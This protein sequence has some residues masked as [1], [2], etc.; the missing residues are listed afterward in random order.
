MLY[1]PQHILVCHPGTGHTLKNK[2]IKKKNVTQAQVAPFITLLIVDDV[3]GTNQYVDNRS[4]FACLSIRIG[5]LSFKR[6]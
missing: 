5:I 4:L 3:D 6:V 1:E 2:K